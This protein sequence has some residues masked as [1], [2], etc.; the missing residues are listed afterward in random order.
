MAFPQPHWTRIYSTNP[1]ER[2]NKEVKRRSKV[3]E[4]FPGGAATIRLMGTVQLEIDDQWQAA[5]Q[6]AGCGAISRPNPLPSDPGTSSS[7]LTIGKF[8]FAT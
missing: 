2:L 3:V 5:D 4:V 1:L 6:L 7:M 8:T